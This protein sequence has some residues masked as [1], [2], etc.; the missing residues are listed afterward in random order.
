L[1]YKTEGK[2]IGGRLFQL[3]NSYLQDRKIR[4]V[5]DGAKSHWYSLFAGVFQGSILG[6][7]L[8][9]KN[10]ECDVHLYADDTVLITSY[11]N[12]EETFV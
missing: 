11:R 5:L 8:F 6:P 9:L 4:V 3:L 7:L 1:K 12:P 10:L 2:G